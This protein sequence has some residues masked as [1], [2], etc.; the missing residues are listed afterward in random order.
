MIDLVPSLF[1]ELLSSA[2]FLKP[3]DCFLKVSP[4]MYM[5][6]GND[7]IHPLDGT[8]SKD[9]PE[10]LRRITSFSQGTGALVPTGQDRSLQHFVLKQTWF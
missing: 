4:D 6:E 7:S 2:C 10:M 1:R 8:D 5:I 3:F 9:A